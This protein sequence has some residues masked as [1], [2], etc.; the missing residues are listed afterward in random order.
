MTRTESNSVILPCES[1]GVPTP[2]VTWTK[3]G[4]PLE[5][6]GPNMDLMQ[7]GSLR[8]SSLKASDAGIYQC[9]ATNEEG[10]AT[11]TI[12]LQINSKYKV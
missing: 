5:I 12:T 1:A 7:S 10:V 8:L 6:V 2:T 4:E 3:N 11:H 9:T